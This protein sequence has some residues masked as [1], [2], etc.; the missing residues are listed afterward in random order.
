MDSDAL[1]RRATL[2]R[3]ATLDEDEDKDANSQVR[4]SFQSETC[5]DTRAPQTQ[6]IDLAPL[7]KMKTKKRTRTRMRTRTRTR[8]RMR[9]RI[10]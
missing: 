10:P 4:C 3:Y 9:M 6:R 8:M 5:S 1:K 7:L 2:A